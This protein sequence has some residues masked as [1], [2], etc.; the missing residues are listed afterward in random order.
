GHGTAATRRGA[1]KGNQ[2]AANN[3]IAGGKQAGSAAA[4]DRP[5]RIC[6]GRPCSTSWG[7]FSSCAPISNRRSWVILR[8]QR[9]RLHTCL[10]DGI[11][12]R[13]GKLKCY[14]PSHYW[15]KTSRERC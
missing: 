12:P 4:R 14:K 10:P 7:S 6:R 2:D 11:L 13:Q 15:W 3:L 5:A 9:G 8:I 1:V